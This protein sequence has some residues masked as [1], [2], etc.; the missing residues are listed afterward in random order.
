MLFHTWIFLAFFLVVYPVFLLLKRTR[1]KAPWLWLASYAF[2]GYANPLYLLLIFWST[3]VDYLA[4]VAMAKT[5]WK[6]PWLTCSIVNNMLLL[7]FFKYGQFFVDNLN[8][9]A[10]W[11]GLPFV[12]SQPNF[13]F[14]STTINY[15]AA[16][17]GLSWTMS[18]IDLPPLGVSFFVFQS[19]SYT[20]DYY[21][22][23]VQRETSF[24]RY[25]TFV[26][27]FPQ[28]V[29][30]PI[31]RASNLLPQLRS[32]TKITPH[33]AA[34]GA[35]L[36]VVG[37]FKKIALAD[38]LA[39]YVN[40]CYGAPGEYGAPALLLATFAF[41]WQIYFDFSGY[42]DMA[43]GLGRMMG[44]RLMLNFNNPYLAD[45]L[46]DFW[47]RWHISLS[48]WFRDYVYVPLGG[49]RRG[50][51]R[52]YVNM[53]L[54]MLISGLWHGAMWTFFLWGAVHA[55]GRLLTRG[56]EGTVFY[57]KHVPRAVKQL[58]TFSIVTF[59]W[60]FFRA[61]TVS[62]AWL[63]VSRIATGGW[64]DPRF[65]LLA[66]GLVV[67]VWAY[68]YIYES[69]LRSLLEP[70]PVRIALVVAMIVYMATCVTAGGQAFI[71]FQF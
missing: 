23:R 3:T 39:M 8:A 34:D 61:E 35:S 33:D 64:S 30:G 58:I 6:K 21:R 24:I 67:A 1:L 65:P 31:E 46:G 37:L 16:S 40:P 53:V 25:A 19:M 38:Y 43:R 29:A 12:L 5:R 51:F 20:I 11:L 4:V 63:I 54:T 45:G 22:G 68:Q 42:T 15:L 44:F 60:I 55:V 47:Q 10:A 36:F 9:L 27:L 50:K 28:L 7:G 26:S 56:L 17:M 49:N 62:D 14:L 13:A 18:P 57:R 71:Y 66:A 70:A 41:A 52:T 59:A 69:R 32:D 2:Y 48:T